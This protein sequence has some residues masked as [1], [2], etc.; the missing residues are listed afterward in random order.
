MIL[1]AVAI[2]AA[3]SMHA[4]LEEG[5]LSLIGRGTIRTPLP[6]PKNLVAPFVDP[7]VAHVVLIVLENAGPAD[8]ERQSFL[9]DRADA[10][11]LL[12]EYYA[13]A[14]P[15]LPNYV[16]MI[17]GSIAGTN[18]DLHRTLH[19]S[20]LGDLLPNRW[21]VYAEDYPASGECSEVSRDGAYVRRHVPFLSFEGVDC[22]AIVRLNSDRTTRRVSSAPPPPRDVVSVTKALRDDIANGTLPAFALVVP[23]LEDDG[24]GPSDIANANDWL[25]RYF[26]PLLSDPA[27][28]KD[29]VFI[30]T[31]DEDEHVNASHPNRVFA[32]VWG[33]HVLQG[34]DGDVYDHEDLFLT[35]AALLHVAPLPQTDEND[36][37]PISGIWK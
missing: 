12:T 30:L 15:S 11:M 4:Q 16:A 6:K 36:S 17:S 1:L 7:G 20:H 32:V 25:T 10:G 2:A 35:I 9:I 22:H 13:V 27:F 24:H 28:T 21:K 23:N 29:T 18:G 5:V 33:D 3:P 37:R 26:A 31:F 34:T 14:H 8:A 19:R